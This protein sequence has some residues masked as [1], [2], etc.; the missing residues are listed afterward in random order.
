MTEL[1]KTAKEAALSAAE[2]LLD[3]F[4]KIRTSDIVEKRQNDFLTYVDEQSENRILTVIKQKYPT[5]TILAEE[6][7]SD[8]VQSDYQWIIDPLD[9]TKNYISGVPV[10]SISI[11]LK[12]KNDIVL[13]VVY[14][15][16]RRELFHAKKNQ[17][18]YLNDRQ[19][20]V[21]PQSHMEKCLLATGFP[22]KYK[23]YL[24]YYIPCFEEVFKNISGIRRM[25]SAA[26]DLAYVASGKF[27]GFWEIALSPWDIAAGI[28]LIKEAGG[29]V[30]DFWGKENY[31]ANEYFLA[32]NGHIHKEMLTILQKHFEK[33]EPIREQETI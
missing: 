21:S 18:A 9:G 25:G 8:S 28:I 14:D 27:E 29:T 5:H 32:T 7:G 15:P 22:F 31:I 16:L 20:H 13:G 30:S 17:G 1:L 2:V 6:S 11:A 24:K 26:I 19:I 12:I 10:F 4:G 23:N 33:Y 3:N